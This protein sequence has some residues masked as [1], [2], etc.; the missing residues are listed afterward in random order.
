[1]AKELVERVDCPKMPH[2]TEPGY[3]SS[4]DLWLARGAIVAV[5]ALQLGLINTVLFRAQWL[6]PA[7][8][9][10]LLIPLIALSA[11]GERL[12]KAATRSGEWSRVSRYRPVLKI[13]AGSLV[14]IVS[15]ANAFALFTV[16]RALLGGRSTGGRTLLIDALNIWATNVI[17]FALWYW[18]LDR[19]GP[20]LDRT[21]HHPPSDFLFP[22]MVAPR[23]N[24][25]ASEN[26]GFVDYL[27]L[28]FTTCTAFSPTD[29]LPLTARMKLLM[30]FEALISLLTIAL[31]AARAVNILA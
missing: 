15:V 23:E 18:E 21:V 12:A 17:I 3:V 11:R 10:V 6:A 9:V 30:L 16:V 31:V 28:S 5:I 25:A 1:M 4:L 13:L 8:E 27:F 19:G 7:L 2:D 14:T 20:S 22:Q 29:T 24:P 26:P